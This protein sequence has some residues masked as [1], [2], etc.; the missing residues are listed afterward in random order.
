MSSDWGNFDDGEEHHA[1][2]SRGSTF[3]VIR[4]GAWFYDP[5]YVRSGSRNSDEPV[6]RYN[7]LGFRL[8]RTIP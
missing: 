1:K 7:S 6:N 8:A 2:C 5:A 3:R 4:G